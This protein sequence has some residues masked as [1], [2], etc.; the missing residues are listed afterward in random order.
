MPIAATGTF[1]MTAKELWLT[2]PQSHFSLIEQGCV[3]ME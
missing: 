1:P 2:T 3:P